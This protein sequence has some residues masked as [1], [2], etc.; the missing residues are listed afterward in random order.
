MI[1]AKNS[2]E[3]VEHILTVS[4]SSH[5]LVDG[6]TKPFAESLNIDI[7]TVFMSAISPSSYSPKEGEEVEEEEEEELFTFDEA[8][9][10]EREFEKNLAAFYMHTSGSTGHPKLVSQVSPF[11]FIS[12]DIR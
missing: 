7:P 1:S 11:N 3:A 6:T 5:L 4:N 10:E 2:R 9:E 8:T 12:S